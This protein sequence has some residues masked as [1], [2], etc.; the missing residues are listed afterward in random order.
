MSTL[1][2]LKQKALYYWIRSTEGLFNFF[3]SQHHYCY[4]WCPFYCCLHQPHLPLNNPP[5][6][7]HPFSPY[8]LPYQKIVVLFRFVFIVKNQYGIILFPGF[9]CPNLSWTSLFTRILEDLCVEF[10]DELRFWYRKRSWALPPCRVYFRHNPFIYVV[11]PSGF[12]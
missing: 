5:P 7:K 10:H 9:K 12:T 1:P 8:Y 3:P 2:F 4:N 6:T 11:F